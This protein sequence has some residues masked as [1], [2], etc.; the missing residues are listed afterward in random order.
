MM[1]VSH[2]VNKVKKRKNT[3]TILSIHL[4]RGKYEG[5]AKIYAL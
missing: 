5:K 3:Y 2:R 1:R 4:N